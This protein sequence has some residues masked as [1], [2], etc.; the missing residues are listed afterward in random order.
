MGAELSSNSAFRNNIFIDCGSRRLTAV[1]MQPVPEI[2]RRKMGKAVHFIQFWKFKV[3]R[4]NIGFASIT[5]EIHL[6]MKFGLSKLP[7]RM[8]QDTYI[9]I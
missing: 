2:K 6:K 7:P 1:I 3:V 8:L 5:S 9:D 4:K